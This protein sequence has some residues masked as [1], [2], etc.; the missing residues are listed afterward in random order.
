M[1]QSEYEARKAAHEMLSHCETLQPEIMPLTR[2]HWSLIVTYGTTSIA[3]SMKDFD[4]L[5][6]RLGEIAISKNTTRIDVYRDEKFYR[7][8]RVDGEYR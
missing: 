1:K 7:T 3:E 4:D 5:C 6:N 2:S 8:I